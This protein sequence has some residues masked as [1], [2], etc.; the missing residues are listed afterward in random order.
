[1]HFQEKV[2]L[3]KQKFM[4]GTNRLSSESGDVESEDDDYI[5]SLMKSNKYKCKDRKRKVRK[6]RISEKK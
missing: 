3:A 6:L 5:L 4:Y 1:M 2:F